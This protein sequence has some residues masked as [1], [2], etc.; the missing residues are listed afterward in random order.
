MLMLVSHLVLYGRE[1]NRTLLKITFSVGQEG[2]R[3]YFSSD[4]IFCR[5]TN[6]VL[7]EDVTDHVGTSPEVFLQEHFTIMP[8]Y[9]TVDYITSCCTCLCPTA[10]NRLKTVSEKSGDR[11]RLVEYTDEIR[12]LLN[13]ILEPLSKMRQESPS[14]ETTLQHTSASSWQEREADMYAQ[15][16]CKAGKEAREEE[17]DL[18]QKAGTLSAADSEDYYDWNEQFLLGTRG[19]T[20]EGRLGLGKDAVRGEESRTE[21]AVRNGKEE[22]E[23]RGGAGGGGGDASNAIYKGLFLHGEEDGDGEEDGEGDQYFTAM[24]LDTG[25]AQTAPN[26]NNDDIHFK[27]PY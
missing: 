1:I 20:E 23:N 26:K 8:Q 4:C 6:F 2:K 7:L 10:L 12:S 11:V 9:C 24:Y 16:A 25:S 13:V 27:K 18:V 5:A 15:T 19:E 3:R 22:V 21:I 17:G 14:V